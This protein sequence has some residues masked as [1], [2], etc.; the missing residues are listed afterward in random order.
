MILGDLNADCS[1][2]PQ[3]QWPNISL[4][5]REEFIWWIGDSVDTTVKSTDCAYDR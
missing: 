2:V 1:Y 4:R 3:S 5:T